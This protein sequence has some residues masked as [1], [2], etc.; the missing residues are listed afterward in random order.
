MQQDILLATNNRRLAKDFK[1]VAFENKQTKLETI[2]K[3]AKLN[4]VFRKR[5]ELLDVMILDLALSV[6][7]LNRLIFYVKRYQKDLP[8][9]LLHM[10]RSMS[11][12]DSEALRNLSVYG[13][14]SRPLNKEQAEYILDDLNNILDLDM[15]KKLGKVEYLEQEKVFA[16]TFKNM[17]TYFLSRKDIPEDDGS[18]IKHFPIDKDEYHFT[19]CLE[20][21]KKY[22]IPWDFIL[23]ICEEEYEFFKDRPVERISSEEIGKRVKK[24]RKLKQLRQ[25]DL[26]KKTK[27]LRANI[28]RIESGRHCPTL[29]TLEKIAEALETPVAK[30][31][32]L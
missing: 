23:H 13:C 9:I 28:A 27:I 15:D 18:K 22:A 7:I 11:K 10:G 31:L 6:E 20:S 29:E 4:E 1:E 32:T 21:G 30:F 8:V 12:K 17:R 5:G 24:E 14:I 19:V 16:C 26:A 3:P 25:E 2:D